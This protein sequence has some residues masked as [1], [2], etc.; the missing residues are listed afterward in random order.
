MSVKMNESLGVGRSHLVLG[1][2]EAPVKTHT[3]SR[4]FCSTSSPS[5][6][7]FL[8]VQGRVFACRDRH[9]IAHRR[10][11]ADQQQF[12][13]RAPCSHSPGRQTPAR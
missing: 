2:V 7:I 13:S 3:V 9:V 10:G 5:P 1:G 4:H 8:S 12:H 6:T 11:Q